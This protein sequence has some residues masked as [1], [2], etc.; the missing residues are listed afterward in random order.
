MAQVCG[1]PPA[2]DVGNGCRVASLSPRPQREGGEAT[3]ASAV[4]LE[5]EHVLVTEVIVAAG[6]PKGTYHLGHFRQLLDSNRTDRHQLL[7]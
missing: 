4:S 1:D 2:F 7:G 6:G 3:E 5:H